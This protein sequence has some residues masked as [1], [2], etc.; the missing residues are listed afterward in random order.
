MRDKEVRVPKDNGESW[1]QNSKPQIPELQGKMKTKSLQEYYTYNMTSNLRAEDVSFFFFFLNFLNSCFSSAAKSRNKYTKEVF[2]EVC[3]S[4]N[5]YTTDHVRC[6]SAHWGWWQRTSET[7]G[8]WLMKRVLLMGPAA[9]CT[10]TPGGRG[11]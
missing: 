2:I 5:F 10:P 9:A 8:G 6:F 4:R 11:L 1:T 7:G 3:F